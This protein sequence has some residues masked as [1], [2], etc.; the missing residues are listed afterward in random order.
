MFLVLISTLFYPVES[1]FDYVFCWYG[2]PNAKFYVMLGFFISGNYKTLLEFE[3]KFMCVGE[4]PIFNSLP[5]FVL[6]PSF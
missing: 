4:P 3:F 5:V 6:D 2:F 1:I